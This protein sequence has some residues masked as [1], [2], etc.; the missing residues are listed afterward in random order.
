MT[1][2]TTPTAVTAATNVTSRNTN[3]THF[4]ATYNN[5]SLNAVQLADFVKSLNGADYYCFQKEKGDNGT[6]HWQLYFHCSKRVKFATVHNALKRYLKKLDIG[7][8]DEAMW[9]KVAHHPEEYR[10]YCRKLDSRLPGDETNGPFTWGDEPV[11]AKQQ[12]KRSEIDDAV[13]LFI[14]GK[15]ELEVT[16][17]IGTSWLRSRRAI[18]DHVNAVKQINSDAVE[19]KKFSE[20]KLRPWQQK[21]ADKL[22]NPPDRDWETKKYQFD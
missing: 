17:Q 5:P 18:L 3:N 22:D 8:P 7:R 1:S 12:G 9:L 4:A 14:D 2:T 10:D 20:V 21:L 16:N 15:N 6:P 13:Q 19:A 11:F